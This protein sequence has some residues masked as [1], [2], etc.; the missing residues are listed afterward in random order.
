MRPLAIFPLG[1]VDLYGK[2][3]V[4]SLSYDLTT[5][6]TTT[7]SSSTNPVYGLG[8][9]FRLG[10]LGFRLQGDYFDTDTEIGKSLVMYSGIV[11]WTF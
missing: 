6:G 10:S 3:G 5:N 11:T 7:N 8:I 9:G 4:A 1:P 2:V